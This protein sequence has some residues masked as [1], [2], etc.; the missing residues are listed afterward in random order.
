MNT[1]NAV[2]D[3]LKNIPLNTIVS[4]EYLQSF[5]EPGGSTLF[6]QISVTERPDVFVSK[7]YEG[8]VGII[9]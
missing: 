2:I 3:K 1:V 5:L 8:R 7:L 9:V 4:S 6:S